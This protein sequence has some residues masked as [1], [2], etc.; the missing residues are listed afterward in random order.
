VNV[1]EAG[2]YSVATFY[3][4]LLAAPH[5]QVCHQGGRRDGL[6]REEVDA[7]PRGAAQ[8]ARTVEKKVTTDDLEFT[9]KTVRMLGACGLAPVMNGKREDIPG[10]DA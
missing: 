9:V 7:N 3:E 1:S 6:P 8:G 5:G 2:I 4:K 10:D